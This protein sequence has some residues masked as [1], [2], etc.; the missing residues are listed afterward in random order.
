MGDM[1][2]FIMYD[3][4]YDDLLGYYEPPPINYKTCRLCG[5]KNL[6]WILTKDNKWRLGSPTTH[7]IHNCTDKNK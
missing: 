5:Q 7:L 6:V 4:P 2:D 1:A 3:D